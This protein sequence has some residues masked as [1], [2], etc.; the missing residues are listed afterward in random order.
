MER[1]MAAKSGNA[2]VAR[3]GSAKPAP[4]AKKSPKPAKAATASPSPKPVK[5]AKPPKVAKAK[6]PASEQPVAAAQPAPSAAAPASATPEAAAAPARQP[7]PV[8]VRIVAEMQKVPGI[9]A[10]GLG[11]SRSIGMATPGSDYDVIMFTEPEGNYDDDAVRRAVARLGGKW[12]TQRERGLAECEVEGQKVELLFRQ[13]DKIAAEIGRAK[14]G[15]FRRSLN[16]LHTVGFLSTVL[17]SYVTY[18][19]PL[20]DPEGRLRRLIKSAFPYPEPLRTKMISGFRTESKL[21]IMHAAK[22]RSD[23]DIAHLMGLYSRAHAA[24]T[25]TLFALNRRY[26][27]IDKGGRHIVTRFPLCPA[28]FTARSKAV[29]RA[30][31]AGELKRALDEAQRIDTEIAIM[32]K[33]QANA[34]GAAPTA[35]PQ[36]EIAGQQA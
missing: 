28:N 27:I 26:P 36:Q 30:A 6:A 3:K 1:L 12:L 4:A 29:F 25:L 10:V 2:P 18:I 13:I 16:P 19:R 24:W 35:K 21:A 5:A 22:T 15:Q 20:W 31:A 23:H 8:L 7:N 34:P 33:A 17:V 9:F 11:G 14:Q 32:C